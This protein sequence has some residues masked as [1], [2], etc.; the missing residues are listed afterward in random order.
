VILSERHQFKAAGTL[1]QTDHVIH[2]CLPDSTT[3]GDLIHDQPVDAIR[4][5]SATSEDPA[6][7]PITLPTDDERATT[8][9]VPIQRFEETPVAHHRAEPRFHARR[10]RHKTIDIAKSRRLHLHQPTISPQNARAQT[11]ILAWRPSGKMQP[12]A[13]KSAAL[14]QI[15]CQSAGQRV[16]PGHDRLRHPQRRNRSTAGLA[17]NLRDGVSI[18]LTQP[19]S[20]TWLDDTITET[21]H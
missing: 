19:S 15:T 2:Q 17:P 14:S 21:G 10:Q 3:T 1:T 9:D 7:Q 11:E 12:S 8:T 16:N 5:R 20:P 18:H 6:E 13:R 4:R